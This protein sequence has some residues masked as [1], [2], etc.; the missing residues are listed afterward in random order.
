MF[1][2]YSQEISKVKLL[3]RDVFAYQSLYF[4][5]SR[6]GIML[7]FKHFLANEADELFSYQV[8][9]NKPVAMKDYYGELTQPIYQYLRFL[10]TYSEWIVG[11]QD[12]E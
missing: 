10:Q 11:V 4:P 9:R 12:Y 5:A 8:N 6:T 2:K 1:S 7:L 3:L